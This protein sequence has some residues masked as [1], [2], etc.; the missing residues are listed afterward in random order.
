ML[1]YLSLGPAARAV[2]WV[3]TLCGCSCCCCCCCCCC[4]ACA[5]R[6]HRVNRSSSVSPTPPLHSFRFK[7]MNL[8]GSGC[9]KFFWP[10]RTTPMPILLHSTETLF[11]AATHHS[12]AASFNVLPK[13]LAFCQQPT[14]R[15]DTATSHRS[16]TPFAPSFLSALAPSASGCRFRR[17]RRSCRLVVACFAV[18]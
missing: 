11:P 8:R 7:L 10:H 6:R 2:V 9:P 15:A 12:F 3:R 4:T 13:G 5:R 16:D 1:M 18:Q 14:S 17:R